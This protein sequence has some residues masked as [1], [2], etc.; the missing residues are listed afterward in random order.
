MNPFPPWMAAGFV[1]RRSSERPN[2][3]P[4][5]AASSGAMVAWMWSEP[6]APARRHGVP[7]IG[8][9][10]AISSGLSPLTPRSKPVGAPA[11]SRGDSSTC[12]PTSLR[13]A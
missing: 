8:A 6:P 7:E 12:G 1:E 4:A 3:A 2:E 13:W 10:A 5:A 9:P 11:A